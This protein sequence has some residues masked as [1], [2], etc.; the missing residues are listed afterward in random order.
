MA[1]LWTRLA[2]SLSALLLLVASLSLATPAYASTA[3]RASSGAN[4]LICHTDNPA[5]CYPRLFQATHEF[6]P[7]HEDQ[8]LPPGL[9]VR[10]NVWT[11]EREA[12]INNASE[13]GP[14]ALQGLAV[15]RSVVLVDQPADG[16]A[17]PILP[18]GAPVYD[19]VGMVKEPVRGGGGHEAAAFAAAVATI[20]GGVEMQTQFGEALE[21]L[22]EF[23]HDMYYGSQLAGDE[24]AAR[25]LLC[26]MTAR[27]GGS[28]ARAQQAA[29]IV[30]AA[31]QN[32]PAALRAMEQAWGRHKA[33]VCPDDQT[34]TLGGRVFASLVPSSRGQL[35]WVR[36]RLS[37]INGLLKSDAIM[38]DFLGSDG[39]TEMLRLLVT[40][41]GPEHESTRARAAHLV[42]D[43]FLDGDMGADVTLW[44]GGGTAT[45]ADTDRDTSTGGA[46]GTDTDR[47]CSQ[48]MQAHCWAYQAQK[49]AEAYGAS[50][51]A[52]TH[53]S[54]E[55]WRLVQERQG[56]KT[57][58]DE[59]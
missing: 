48:G 3:S 49:L 36:S 41:D 23:A 8:D 53:W 6:Q 1:R 20:K 57:G 33:A 47:E 17:E 39:L 29:A 25:L 14:A 12:K 45:D 52:S 28:D 44:P 24:A 56:G 34:S 50:A 35:A 9:H 40:L 58:R 30:A 11:G 16:P 2:T 26:L 42:M 27:D 54:T 59:L 15:D 13:D 38:Q 7:V 43:N 5:E 19:P 4:D 51:D 10:L 32:N 18:K 46:P 22:D 21:Q 55:L 37:A 31:V